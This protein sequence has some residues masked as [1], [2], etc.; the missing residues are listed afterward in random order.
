[1]SNDISLDGLASGLEPGT[2]RNIMHALRKMADSGKT[3]VLF[4]HSTLQ[5]AL[6]DK[7]VLMGKS[8]NLH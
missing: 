7:F 2:E 1:M 6:C 4:T 3:V 8:V 5:L